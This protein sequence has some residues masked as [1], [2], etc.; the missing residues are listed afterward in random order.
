MSGMELAS[1]TSN[2]R[3][4]LVAATVATFAGTTT[5]ISRVRANSGSGTTNVSN[6]NLIAI[7]VGV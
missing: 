6:A 7:P 3:G 4:S 2:N 1:G 5:V